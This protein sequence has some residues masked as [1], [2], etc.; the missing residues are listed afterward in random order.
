MKMTNSQIIKSLNNIEEFKKSTKGKLI[1]LK[2]SFLI[3]KNKRILEQ[4]YLVYMEELEHINNDFSVEVIKNDEEEKL[5]LKS[6]SEEK[7]KEYIKRF[8]ELSFIKVDVKINTIKEEDFGTYE[9]T[10]EE[11]DFLGF[12]L[13]I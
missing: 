10:L 1:P 5:N 11:V 4:E 9:P 2:L 13:D 7:R 8:N 3:T 12:M 6:L